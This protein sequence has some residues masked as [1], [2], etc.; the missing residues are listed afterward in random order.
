M[1]FRA[2]DRVILA[3]AEDH[4]LHVQKGDVATVLVVENDVAWIYPDRWQEHDVPRVYAERCYKGMP[5]YR[6]Y[7]HR[8]K[9]ACM[10]K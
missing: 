10:F 8:L 6:V 2:G 4:Y 3:L 5:Y 9:I 7:T 1:K